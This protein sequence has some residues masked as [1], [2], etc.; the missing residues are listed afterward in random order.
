MYKLFLLRGTF[1]LVN[2]KILFVCNKSHHCLVEIENF[3]N[4]FKKSKML[5]MSVILKLWTSIE[6][7]TQEKR[8]GIK[9]FNYRIFWWIHQISNIIFAKFMQLHFQASH[10]FFIDTNYL[11]GPTLSY[12][13]LNLLHISYLGPRSLL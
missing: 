5:S 4:N 7:P 2:Q 13:L 11:E 12:R 9:K 6:Q 8:V 1:L 10:A 3:A